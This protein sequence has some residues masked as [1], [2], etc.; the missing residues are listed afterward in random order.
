MSQ[1]L[2]AISL[3][4]QLLYG[5]IPLQT[6]EESTDP[7]VP[8]PELMVSTSDGRYGGCFHRI[9]TPLHCRRQPGRL[10]G[11]NQ[12][13]QVSNCSQKCNPVSM[14]DLGIGDI[15]DGRNPGATPRFGSAPSGCHY[16]VCIRRHL[17]FLLYLISEDAYKCL[18]ELV[19]VL[20]LPPD[21]QPNS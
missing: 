11:H 6:S 4:L 13:K 10:S 20:V 7:T 18:L 21:R 5:F 19:A 3:D 15:V 17:L 14:G 12:G 1:Q 9:S 8:S 16:R 2:S